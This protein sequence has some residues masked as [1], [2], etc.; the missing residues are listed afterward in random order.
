VKRFIGLILAVIG[1]GI[2]LWAAACLLLP[3]TRKTIT[4]YDHTYHA[5]Y[6]GLVGVALLTG[7]LVM[8]QD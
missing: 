2:C 1:A 4:I 6:P 8:R 3:E 7:G 5:M